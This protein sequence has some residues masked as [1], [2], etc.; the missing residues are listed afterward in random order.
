MGSIAHGLFTPTTDNND[1]E[2]DTE[3]L[4]H[5]A[6]TTTTTG[7]A[8]V[9]LNATTIL[10]YLVQLVC[11]TMTHLL[12]TEVLIPFSPSPPFLFVPPL[13][14]FPLLS[15]SLPLSSSFPFFQVFFNCPLALLVLFPPFPSHFISS[16]FFSPF[17]I[18]TCTYHTNTTSIHIPTYPFYSILFSR[19]LPTS[20]NNNSIYLLHV[21]IPSPNYSFPPWV[22]IQ[23]LQSWL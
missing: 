14:P 20:N 13:S 5:H 7:D 9:G 16:F 8:K 21:S 6:T 19:S 3:A 1:D 10:R 17:R 4:S 18:S 22:I 12:H 15:P 11:Q 23:H 2:N